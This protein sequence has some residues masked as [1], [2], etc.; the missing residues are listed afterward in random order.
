[1]NLKVLLIGM[2]IPVSMLFSCS[3]LGADEDENANA[4]QQ[5]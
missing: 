3:S 2:V 1:M 5:R 4:L